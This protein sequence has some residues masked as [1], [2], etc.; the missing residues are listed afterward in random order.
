MIFIIEQLSDTSPVVSTIKYPS[1][2]RGQAHVKN[3]LPDT[4]IPEY[5]AQDT[6]DRRIRL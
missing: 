3:R 4:D 2:G 6:K 1:E 5:A